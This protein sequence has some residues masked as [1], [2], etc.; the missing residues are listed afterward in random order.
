M[1]KKICEICK[2]KIK[3]YTHDKCF[4]PSIS[5]IPKSYKITVEK[6]TSTSPIVKF[7]QN[8]DELV[9]YF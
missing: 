1:N 5:L 7:T 4:Q 2:R 3:G 6:G 8:P 9:V